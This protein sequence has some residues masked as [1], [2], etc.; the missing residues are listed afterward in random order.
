MMLSV[1]G[2]LL[3]LENGSARYAASSALNPGGTK[4]ALAAVAAARQAG[5]HERDH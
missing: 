3:P 4:P 2:C 5:Y 1:P